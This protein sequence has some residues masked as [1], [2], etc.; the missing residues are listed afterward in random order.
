MAP[1]EQG[2]PALWPLVLEIVDRNCALG[3]ITPE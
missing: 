3:R 1:I 2:I